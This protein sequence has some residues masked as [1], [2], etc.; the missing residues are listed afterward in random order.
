M[1]GYPEILGRLPHPVVGFLRYTIA[2]YSSVMSLVILV[3]L[4]PA[5]FL[6]IMK[7]PLMA[8]IWR[9][10]LAHGSWAAL[11]NHGILERLEDWYLAVFLVSTALRGLNQ[12]FGDS[13]GWF[14]M[15]ELWFLIELFCVAARFCY[16]SECEVLDLSEREV[17]DLECAAHLKRV[18]EEE[19]K[20]SWEAPASPCRGTAPA[21]ANSAVEPGPRVQ[22]LFDTEIPGTAT[23]L[24]CN[25]RNNIGEP[26]GRSPQTP[27]KSYAG[28]NRIQPVHSSWSWLLCMPSKV[29][30]I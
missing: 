26:S 12:L 21:R 2:W 6:L 25:G 11:C 9:L 27:L 17:L 30:K 7:A 13:W 16:T 3:V 18:A 10:M 4:L 15:S 28:S 23:E 29:L 22:T 8:T 20:S 1:Y 24:R 19:S 14:L 5:S